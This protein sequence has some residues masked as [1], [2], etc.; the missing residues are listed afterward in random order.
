M[1]IPPGSEQASPGL[2]NDEGPEPQ[3][4]MQLLQPQTPKMSTGQAV[5]L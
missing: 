3:K 4:Q 1:V 2:A 5:L